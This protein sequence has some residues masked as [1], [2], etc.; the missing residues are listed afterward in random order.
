VGTSPALS[1]NSATVYVVVN[2]AN[3]KPAATAQSVW[4]SKDGSVNIA[5]AGTDVETTS[6]NLVATIGTQP[7]HGTLT[8]VIGNQYLY[9]PAAGYDGSDSFTFTVTDNGDPAGVGASPALSSNP[10]TVYVVVNPVNVKPVA[11]AQSVSVSEDGSVN[12]TLAGTDVETASANLVA[13]LK[14]QPV[15]GTLTLVSGNQYLYT[16]AANYNG[17]DSFAFTVTDDGSPAGSHTNPADLTS[18]PATVSITVIPVNDAPVATAQSVTVNEDGSV[19]I[20]LASTDVETF[21]TSLVAAIGTQPAHGTLA[22]ISRNLCRYMPAANYNGSDSFTFTVTDNGDPAGV[23]TSPALSSNPTTVSI[24]VTPANDRPTATAQS[25]TIDEDG[26]VNITLAGTDV[27]TAAANLVAAN[28]TQPA[29]G[30][31]TLVSGNQYRYTPAANYNGQD[32]FTFTV[33]DNGDPA[34]V[35]TSPALASSP[36]TVSITVAPVNDKPVAQPQSQYS[37]IATTLT[38]TLGATD[39]ETP[40]ANMTFNIPARSAHGTLTQASHGVYT[41][42]PDATYSG[43]DSFTFTVTDTGDPAA[44]SASALTS[45][46]ATVGLSVYRKQ[47]FTSKTKAHYVDARGNKVTVSLSGPGSGDLYFVADAGLASAPGS[48]DGYLVAAEPPPDARALVLNETTAA[49][50]VMI[51][52]APSARTTIQ[53]II[54]NGALASL[55]G[56][57]T[58]LTGDIAATGAALQIALGDVK[59]P[60]E[61]RVNTRLIALARPP[62][63]S[64]T[65]RDVADCS[66]DTGGLAIGSLRVARWLNTDGKADTIQAP[67]LNTLMVTGR[68]IYSKTGSTRIAGDFEASLRLT[69]LL[70]AG[71]SALSLARISGNLAAAAWDIGGAV[72]ALHVGS[73]GDDFAGTFAGRISSLSAGGNLSGHWTA[74][75]IGGILVCGSLVGADVTLTQGAA[76]ESRATALGYMC[77]RKWI[78]TSSLKSAGTIGS[79][80]AGAIRDSDVFVGVSQTQNV[81][82]NGR[83]DLPDPDA[84][85]D[86]L[87]AI[88]GLI[89]YGLPGEPYA[90]IDSNIAAAD[91]GRVSIRS[92]KGDNG[93]ETFGFAGKHLGSLRCASAVT[94][95][96]SWPNL[97]S[98]GDFAVRVA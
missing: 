32:S 79:I 9:T 60:S 10:A 83:A 94:T 55:T 58:D 82:K 89:I 41:Y 37:G 75:S 35:G 76:P 11:T 65:F 14:T 24:T 86:A 27:E 5:L 25:V 85:F 33:R 8:L 67:G 30:T 46:P 3:D 61:I 47:H 63:L 66:I 92:V 21:P 68:T 39:V 23:G 93:G 71:R 15:H 70:P 16:P 69:G 64:M 84:D 95:P 44:T 45:D 26:W 42:L 49:S 51:T 19:D 22:L 53:D 88:K 54:I 74:R 97:P 17:P 13:A 6:A 96:A 87:A 2:P 80:T 4:V 48:G 77:V 72:G 91:L 98:L 36:A 50:R 90:M 56:R 73:V 57:T 78:D 38:L 52:T 20:A 18:D 34:G 40:Y 7:A 62:Q 12:I 81:R 1:S 29:H 28:S 59:G 43:A 31:L